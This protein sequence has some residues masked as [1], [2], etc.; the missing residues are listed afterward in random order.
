MIPSEIR[1]SSPASSQVADATNGRAETDGGGTETLL[2]S[3]DISTGISSRTE[4]WFLGLGTNFP[5]FS[6]LIVFPG[7]N[8]IFLIPDFP[9]NSLKKQ[10]K[11]TFKK[12]LHKQI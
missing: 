4:V 11:K 9:Q 2:T 10:T 3:I 6:H 12:M 8:L 5:G 7:Q 1:K